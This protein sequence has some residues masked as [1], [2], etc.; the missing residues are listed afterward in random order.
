[1]LVM[2]QQCLARVGD[3]TLVA[4]ALCRGSV[5]EHWSWRRGIP[6]HGDQRTQPTAAVWRALS[7]HPRLDSTHRATTRHSTVQG[8]L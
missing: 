5:S 3:S 2:M 1:M 4:V 6:R 8:L 7:L